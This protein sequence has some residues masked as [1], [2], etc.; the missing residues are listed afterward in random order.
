MQKSFRN[1][2][3]I[4]AIIIFFCFASESQ[5]SSDLKTAVS[6]PDHLA[7]REPSATPSYSDEK[8]PPLA[9]P[10]SAAAIKVDDPVITIRGLCNPDSGKDEKDSKSCITT[11]TQKQFDSLLDAANVSGQQISALARQNFAKGYVLYLAFEQAARK[12]GFEDT[13]E[14]AELMRWARLRAVTDAYRGKIIEGAR[15]AEQTEVDTYYEGHLDLYDRI[16]IATIS[17]PRTRPGASEDKAFDLRAY[18]VM[19]DA[20]QRLIHGD[21]PEEVQ[22]NVYTSLD[23]FGP[24]VVD[25]LTRMRS[26]FPE[27]KPDE[28][29]ALKPGDVSDVQKKNGSYFIYKIVSHDA[30]PESK[31][32]PGIVRAI[33]ENKVRQAFD[34]VESSIQAEYNITYF[35]PP[36]QSPAPLH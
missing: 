15:T 11:V 14:F 6:V 13:E 19:Q 28:I 36:Q 27:L 30:L 29:A 7:G 21:S 9:H 2:A 35:G 1:I 22:K 17:V 32:Q 34:S 12:A 26:D 20:R 10:N 24:P 31:V 3:L 16:S 23:L 25:V 8:T 5:T 33:A 18:M 4:S